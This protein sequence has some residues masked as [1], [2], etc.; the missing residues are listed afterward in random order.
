MAVRA[1]PVSPGFGGPERRCDRMFICSRDIRPRTSSVG[2]FFVPGL[3][4]KLQKAVAVRNPLQG[5]SARRFRRSQIPLEHASWI[6]Q[7]S[8]MLFLQGLGKETGSERFGTA[9][10]KL[11]K[12]PPQPSRVLLSHNRYQCVTFLRSAEMR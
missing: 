11:R 6:F 9:F 2:R 12:R 1:L 10:E 4:R 5:G 7:D 3:S 8:E